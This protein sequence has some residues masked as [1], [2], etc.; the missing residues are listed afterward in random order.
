MEIKGQNVVESSHHS[1]FA[2]SKI[3]KE[4]A[5]P[6]PIPLILS[7]T[8]ESPWGLPQVTPWRS[9]CCPACIMMPNGTPSLYFILIQLLEQTWP[10][11]E[12]SLTL[13]EIEQ[14]DLNS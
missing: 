5:S 2:G 11:V 9:W 14:M 1:T 8:Q 7:P 12:F 3:Q 13:L 10:S 6:I 4:M